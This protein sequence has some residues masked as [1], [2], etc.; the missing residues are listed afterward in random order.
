M[1]FIDEVRDRTDLVT[2]IG[3]STEIKRFTG[4]LIMCKCPFHADGTASLAI[5]VD[6]QRWWCY[7]GCQTGGDCFDWVQRRDNVD[8]IEARNM[9]ARDA[10]LDIP[11]FTPEAPEKKS[12]REQ[13]DRLM[14]IAAN[15]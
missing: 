13:A 15:F 1:T 8:F 12:E 5:Y 4:R 3:R 6:Q 2:L 7:G 10:G 14:I 9:L 11:K